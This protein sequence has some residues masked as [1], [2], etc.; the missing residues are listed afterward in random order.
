MIRDKWILKVRNKCSELAG[1]CNS[2]AA[3]NGSKLTDAEQ[4][5]LQELLRNVVDYIDNKI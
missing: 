1:E 3:I 2:A 5:R 4:D